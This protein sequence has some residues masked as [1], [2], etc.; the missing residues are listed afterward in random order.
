MFGVGLHFSLKDLMAVKS[1]AIPA[2]LPDS[3]GNAAGYGAFSRIRLVA[4]GGDR[5]WSVSFNR[6]YRGCYCAR[7]KND[8]SLTSQRGQIAI[9]WLIV[10]DLMMVLTLVLLP[11][12]AG[13][14]K[15]RRRL[16]L[17]GRRYGI[18]IGK[19]VAFIAIMMLVVVARYRG[20]WPAAP[21]PVPRTVYPLGPRPIAFRYR[22]WRS[23]AVRYLPLRWAR[24][25]P[26]WC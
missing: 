4:D 19:V 5:V 12:V 14:W 7:L 3:S 1:I 22:L 6:Q 15:R 23:R 26:V 18:T 16:R 24:S 9:G 17:A 25:S 13:C 11:A 8:S 10:E 2:R 20:L 21:Q